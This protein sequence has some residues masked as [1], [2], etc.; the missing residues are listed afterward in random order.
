VYFVT[1]MGQRWRSR[2]KRAAGATLTLVVLSAVVVG[3]LCL[4]GSESVAIWQ[5]QGNADTS[6]SAF[7]E[8]VNFAA[9][10][11]LGAR[12]KVQ[13]EEAKTSIRKAEEASLLVKDWKFTQSPLTVALALSLNLYVQAIQAEFFLSFFN[14]TIEQLQSSLATNPSP[15]AQ[16]LNSVLETFQGQVNNLVTSY[17]NLL[18]G[19]QL[20]INSFIPIPF[21]PPPIPPVS[22]CMC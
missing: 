2:F 9:P 19:T 3:A 11:E 1:A 16:F 12:F 15:L 4:L 13:T 6:S 17:V 8:L 20:F 10:A 7:A 22:P 18:R 21:R 5:A 14:N